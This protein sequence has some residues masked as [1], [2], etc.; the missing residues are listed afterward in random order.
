MNKDSPSHRSG[1][2]GEVREVYQVLTGVRKAN[3]FLFF[4]AQEKELRGMK[5]KE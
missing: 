3:I 2:W 5:V 1:G 4:L